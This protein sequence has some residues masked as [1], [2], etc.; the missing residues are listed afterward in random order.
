MG[1]QLK[2][3]VTIYI[4][5]NRKTKLRA[6]TAGAIGAR[7]RTRSTGNVLQATVS[8]RHRIVGVYHNRP[9]PPSTAIQPRSVRRTYYLHSGMNIIWCDVGNQRRK[10]GVTTNVTTCSTIRV[11]I[12]NPRSHTELC[13][14]LPSNQVKHIGKRIIVMVT[15]VT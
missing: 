7:C 2:K 8:L 3:P 4:I 15:I 11:W 9:V 5:D 6:Y 1:N 12:P 10:L 13:V 14:H